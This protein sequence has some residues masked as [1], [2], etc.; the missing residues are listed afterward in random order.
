MEI[1]NDMLRGRMRE[2]TTFETQFSRAR[3]TLHFLANQILSD[4]QLAHEIVEHCWIIGSQPRVMFDTDSA[5]HSWLLRLAMD[6]ALL[7]LD[8]RREGVYGGQYERRP[9]EPVPRIKDPRC[10]ITLQGAG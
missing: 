6:E 1:Q 9:N 4:S 10:N 7:M 8:R 5:F 3:N 2:N